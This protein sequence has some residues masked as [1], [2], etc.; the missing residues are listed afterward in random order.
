[1]S[2]LPRRAADAQSNL[3]TPFVIWCTSASESTTGACNTEQSVPQ[4]VLAKHQNASVAKQIALVVPVQAW[5]V[6]SELGAL[7]RTVVG[8]AV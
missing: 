1:M 2:A 8:L 5:Q 3:L 7:Y 4:G 6:S